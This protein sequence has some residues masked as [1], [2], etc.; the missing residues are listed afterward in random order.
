MLHSG[1]RKSITPAIMLAAL[2]VGITSRSTAAVVAAQASKGAA[3]KSL[4]QSL[5]GDAKANF[6]AA[7]LL[8]TDGDYANALIK[9]RGAYEAS[10]DPRLLWNVAFC[11]KN[12]RHYAKVIATL[13][14]YIEEGRELLTTA[15]QKEAQEL[16]ALIEPFTTRTNIKVTEAGA[17]VY[18]NDELVG[19]SPLATAVIL[20]IGE[21]RLRVVKAGFRSFENALVIG[22]SSEVTVEVVLEKEVHEGKLIVNAP[23]NANIVIDGK[24]VATG[25]FEQTIPSGGH[26][27][28][29]VAPGTRPFQTEVAI[30]DKETR[31]LDVVLEAIAPPEKPK[32]RVRVACA[33]TEPKAPE[34]GLTVYLDGPEVLPA[35]AVRRRWNDEEKRNVVEWVEYSVAPGPHQLR[36]SLTDCRALSTSVNVDSVRG[37]DV[38]GALESDRF[39][40]FRGPLGSPGWHRVA[41]GLYLPTGEARYKVPE[42]YRGDLGD[43]V[44]P[45][46]DLGLVTRWFGAFTQFS[47]GRGSFHRVTY[48]TH[49]ALPEST[50]TTW[51]QWTARVGPRL[52]F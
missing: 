43:V 23:A 4:A 25:K 46:I 24:P 8:A 42:Q 29:V 37:A 44:G 14:Q 18:V 13:Q 49:Y 6:D 52:P 34:D 26:Q 7:K 17:N 9:F 10:H 3:R 31:S 40:L 47:Y 30:A 5:T 48:A 45:T 11:H 20:D 22:G 28:Q 1:L 51:T 35:T 50:N 2:G 38:T 32:L 15:D 19:E 41:L 21:R 16:I 39:V 33:D 12:L 27:I 36:I